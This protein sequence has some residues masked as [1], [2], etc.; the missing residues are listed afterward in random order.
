MKVLSNFAGSRLTSD[1]V[2]EAVLAYSSDLVAVGAAELIDIPVI[3][4]G[5]A[6]L[7]PIVVGA[8][9]GL[10]VGA[11]PADYLMSRQSDTALRALTSEWVR[12]RLGLRG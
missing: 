11:A 6:R 1:E 7:A 10:V 2:A 12:P 3:D 9:T 4:G 5:A 8:L